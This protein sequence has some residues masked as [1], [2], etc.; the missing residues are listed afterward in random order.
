MFLENEL[1]T[2]SL[3]NRLLGNLGGPVSPLFKAKDDHRCNHRASNPPSRSKNG[4]G[5][6]KPNDLF[7]VEFDKIQITLAKTHKHL[8]ILFGKNPS[9]AIYPLF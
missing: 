6:F 9:I 4:C 7:A 5:R 3:E 8:G 2:K 1:V